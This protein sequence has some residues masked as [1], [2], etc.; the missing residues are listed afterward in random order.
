MDSFQAKMGGKM[1]KREKIKIIVPFGSYPTGNINFQ[2]NSKKIQKIK[3]EHYAFFSRQNG[4]EM[5]EKETK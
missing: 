3:N 5:A 2:N 1:M 4:L